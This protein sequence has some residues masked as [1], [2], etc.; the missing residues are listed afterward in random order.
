MKLLIFRPLLPCLLLV[1]AGCRNEPAPK[2][3]V[4]PEVSPVATPAISRPVS[5]ADVVKASV[6]PIEISAGTAGEANLS[7]SIAQG[8]HVNANPATF[9]YLIATAVTAEQSTGITV[10]KPV[11][12]AA[13]MK[14]FSFEKQPLSVYEGTTAVKLPLQLAGNAAKGP[15]SIPLAVRVQA[16]DDAAC[17]APATL[18]PALQ[19]TVK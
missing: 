15:R 8:Y 3:A 17:Y 16:C 5:S 10:G 11:Y 12:P 13:L 6:A 19:L 14:T 9:P 7:I 18:N 1:A 4:P 2:P